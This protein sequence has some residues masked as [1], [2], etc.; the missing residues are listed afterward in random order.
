MNMKTFA[1]IPS[2]GIGKRITSEIPKQFI[3][4]NEKEIIAYTLEVFQQCAEVD[5]IIIPTGKN[6][7]DL[8]N[9]IKGK[10]SITKLNRIVEGGK[11]RQ[12]SV[13]AALKS[14]SADEDDIVI[15][16]DAARPL[17]N[18]NLLSTA[19]NSAEE[20]GSIVVAVK[21]KD[22]LIEGSGLVENYIDRSK[23]YYAQ[24]PQIFRYKIL[25][26]A[27]EN[28]YKNN[29]IGT[30]ESMIVKM[31]NTEVKIVE[32]DSFNFKVTTDSDLELFK[33]IIK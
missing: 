29:F 1:I 11:E 7:F 22:T 24:T 33:K 2:A 20:F 4:V 17:L 30:D 3:K 14:I 6:Y 26:A 13:Y 18:K 8:L 27:I 28:A 21:A 12:D 23:I 10:Y 19:I 15:V 25:V 9:S 32:G 16:H 31:N 5:E